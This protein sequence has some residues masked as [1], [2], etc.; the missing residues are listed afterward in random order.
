MIV[1]IDFFCG[2]GGLT[3]G[4]FE[5]GIKV[6]LGI[7]SNEECGQTYEANNPEAKFKCCDIRKLTI[8]ELEAEI[9][10]VSRHKLMFAACAPCQPFSKQRTTMKDSHQRTLLGCFSKFVEKFEPEYIFVENVP[11]ITKV[12][13]CSTYSRF[14]AMLERLEYFYD[15]ADVDA[16]NYG[17]PQTRRRHILLARKS[18][19][20]RIP[21]PTHGSGRAPFE[22]VSKAISHFPPI[23]AGEIHGVI[24]NHRSSALSDLNMLRIRS[25]PLDGGDRRAWPNDLVLDCHKGTYQGHTDV[26]GRMWWNRPA[27]ALTCKCH[28]LSNGRYG[29]PNQD[30]AISLREAAALQSFPDDYVFYGRSKTS[31]GNQIGNAVP[32]NLAKAMGRVFAEQS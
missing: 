2:A 30:R 22:T 32:V 24:P 4:L 5:S 12:R 27:P 11:G 3:R 20:I 23:K 15:A 31:I 9:S 19:T 10:N 26:Y 14:V 17:V 18:Y 29:H 21:E 1:A 25:T 13:G 28:S 16:K 8:S 7:D 6:M